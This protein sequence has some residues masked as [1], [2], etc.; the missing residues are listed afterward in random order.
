MH[1]NEHLRARVV[2]LI[3]FTAII[4]SFLFFRIYAGK[5]WLMDDWLLL[6]WNASA[7]FIFIPTLRF[8][9]ISIF[10]RDYE[11]HQ[12]SDLVLRRQPR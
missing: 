2:H 10:F 6:G 8:S 11:L 7:P 3:Q 9:F 1:Q 12:P 4:I 5:A